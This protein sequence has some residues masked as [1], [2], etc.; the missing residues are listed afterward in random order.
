MVSEDFFLWSHFYFLFLQ[1]DLFAL[2]PS[3]S[4]S[5]NNPSSIWN[6]SICLLPSLLPGHDGKTRS[7][8]C[9]CWVFY[10]THPLFIR[11][12]AFPCF[13]LLVL[14][15]VVVPVEQNLK[16]TEHDCFPLLPVVHN[17]SEILLCH[18]RYSTARFTAID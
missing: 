14:G 17:Y 13:S 3:I 8:C 10:G 1:L 18:H 6:D 12:C 9:S 4:K 15:R 7:V 5:R 2:C 11:I 16:T